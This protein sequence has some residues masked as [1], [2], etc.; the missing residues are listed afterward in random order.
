M[1]NTNKETLTIVWCDNGNTDGKFTEGLLNTVIQARLV[2]IDIHA[3][4]RSFGNQIARQRQAVFDNWE[5]GIKTDWLLWVDSDIVLTIESLKR[6][7]QAGDKDSVKIV[8][9]LYFVSPEPEKSLMMPIPC[10]YNFTNNMEGMEHLTNL[11]N[12][13]II[14]I[15][16][17][18]M[19]LILM[20]KS[21]IE[22]IRKV[23]ENN[24][25]FAE[26]TFAGSKFVGED[27]SFFINVRKAGI[28]PY[29]HTGA[30]ADHIKR[31]TF[32]INYH[33]FYWKHKNTPSN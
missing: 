2:G 1:I 4:A 3:V 30:T 9:G 8:S 32:D 29:L 13:Q 5:D 7:L 12:D 28:Q 31:F 25:A 6:L 15:D 26:K 33:N 19:G 21:I 14:K 10:A 27:V 17:A 18:G 22:P 23:S 11:P 16:V 20:H 24:F